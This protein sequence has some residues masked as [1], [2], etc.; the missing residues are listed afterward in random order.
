MSFDGRALFLIAIGLLLA[1]CSSG[2]AM[3]TGEGGQPRTPH[4]GYK[5]GEPYQ[6]KGIWYTPH[7]DYSYEETGIA[8]WYGEAFDQ[9]YTANGEV[10]DLNQLTAAHRTLPL[11]SIVEVTNLQNNRA[12]RVRVNDRGPFANGRIVDVSRRVAQLLGFERTGTT[13]VRVRIL[14]DESMEVAALAQRGIISDEGIT[15]TAATAPVVQTAS[16]GPPPLPTRSVPPTP[17]YQPPLVAP[18]P[19][20]QPPPVMQT[21]AYQPA[22]VVPTP[23]P[24]YQSPSLSPISVAEAAPMEHVLRLPSPNAPHRYF[25]QAGTFA[26]EENAWRLRSQIASLGS[27]GVSVASTGGATLYRVRIG[28]M[29]TAAE[30]D[31]LLNR[32]IQI[33]YRD[34]RIVI[35]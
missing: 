13:P 33:G 11:P 34:A 15:T 23:R 5:I 24:T 8:S 6:V 17:V 7:V 32:M 30:A 10:F 31:R 35:D 29:T 21:T 19:T 20:Y 14:K 9:Q 28:P 1:A 2:P 18:A 16:I 25:V 27:V 12:L 3:F 4:P 26:A 22:P